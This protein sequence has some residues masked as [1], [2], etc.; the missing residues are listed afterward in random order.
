MPLLAFFGVPVFVADFPHIE[1]RETYIGDTASRD[2]CLSELFGA[3]EKVESL[4]ELLSPLGKAIKDQPDTYFRQDV[5][6]AIDAL[7]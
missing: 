7:R 1:G 3:K 4:D 2:L 5:G 6:E